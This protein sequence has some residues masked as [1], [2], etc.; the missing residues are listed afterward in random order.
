ME[1]KE[2]IESA[3]QVEV[4]KESYRIHF[5]PGIHLF[6]KWG[7]DVEEKFLSG[8]L[9]AHNWVA[10]SAI[11]RRMREYSP[12]VLAL[13]TVISDFDP[14][15][16][17]GENEKAHVWR[18]LPASPREMSG[19]ESIYVVM[20]DPLY[21]GILRRQVG[22]ESQFADELARLENSA[23]ED[24][25]LKLIREE[26]ATYVSTAALIS[27]AIVLAQLRSRRGSQGDGERRGMSRRKFLA[28]A[29]GIP[30]LLVGA[31]LSTPMM[32]SIAPFERMT[33]FFQGVMEVTRYR[34]S[35]SNW[36]D[37]RTAVLISKTEE[38]MNILKPPRDASAS[39]LMGYPHGYEAPELIRNSQRRAFV[40]RGYAKEMFVAI[41]EVVKKVEFDI[42]KQEAHEALID[43]LSLMDILKVNDPGITRVDNPLGVIDTTI[44]HR[45]HF[46]SRRIRESL[47]DLV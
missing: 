45:G 35:H 18:W 25:V 34:F 13:D 41:D 43:Y 47:K 7:V 38:A 37:G 27:G 19:R 9:S 8:D 21:Q 39:I 30:L 14:D 26:A 6:W 16:V 29:G 42:S 3:N 15:I 40:T 33:D 11:A 20:G 1:R 2:L 4:N 32:A 24:Y 23:I 17:R 12:Q 44:E 31:R 46:K 5:E 36:L 10:G 22:Q 28:L